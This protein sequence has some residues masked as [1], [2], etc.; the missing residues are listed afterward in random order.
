LV[1]QKVGVFS[2]ETS[3]MINVEVALLLANSVVVVLFLVLGLKSGGLAQFLQELIRSDLSLSFVDF[4]IFLSESLLFVVFLKSKAGLF[5]NNGG[6]S[7]FFS[8][9]FL[10]GRLGLLLG[11]IL[12]GLLFSFGGGGGLRSLLV[13]Y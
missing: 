3:V 6:F 8:G 12:F 9:S 7:G 2:G 5:F 13:F 4:L 1:T 10:L 11:F